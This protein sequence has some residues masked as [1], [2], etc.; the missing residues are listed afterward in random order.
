M[1][2]IP[3]FIVTMLLATILVMGMTAVTVAADS[4]GPAPMTIE[5]QIEHYTKIIVGAL[6][7]LALSVATI[8]ALVM[9]LKTTSAALFSVV[10]G[11]DD[12]LAPLK[13]SDPAAYETAKLTLAAEV[14]KNPAAAALV[15]K[16]LDVVDPKE[17]GS[18]RTTAVRPVYR[19]N[20]FGL[21]EAV[22]TGC[23]VIL[24]VMQLMLLGCGAR[25]IPDTHITADEAFIADIEFEHMDMLGRIGHV[26]GVT[27]TAEMIQGR[28]DLFTVTKAELRK[29][30]EAAEK[31]KEKK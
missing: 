21:P 4:V 28:Q 13:H 6:S 16:V 2:P 1:R 23:V 24:L 22:L 20:G 3:W 10:K 29:L 25:S 27:V 17:P 30:R 11:G 5:E 9:K 7:A 14:G 18:R 26:G 15:D 12:A 19:E 31:G 8:T